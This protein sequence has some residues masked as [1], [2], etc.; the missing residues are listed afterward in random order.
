ML[1]IVFT[2]SPIHSIVSTMNKTGL[3]NPC[4]HALELIYDQYSKVVYGMIHFSIPDA[5][6]GQDV[7]E[8]VFSSLG[9][10]D[11]EAIQQRRSSRLMQVT[12]KCI[13]NYIEK[14]KT[15]TEILQYTKNLKKLDDNDLLQLASCGKYN[16]QHLCILTGLDEESLRKK[17]KAVVRQFINGRKYESP[18]MLPVDFIPQYV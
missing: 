5:E 17:L 11:I 6:A 7:L 12:R 13:A 1:G 2:A 8:I 3:P 9:K 15:N 4:R 14:E 10:Q 16:L 18:R